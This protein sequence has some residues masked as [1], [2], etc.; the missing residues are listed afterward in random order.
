MKNNE[1][2]KR[3]EQ[4]V[5]SCDLGGWTFKNAICHKFT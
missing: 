2:D 1:R 3:K 5:M 4:D